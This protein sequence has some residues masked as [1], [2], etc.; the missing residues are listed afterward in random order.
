MRYRC[1]LVVLL[2]AVAGCSDES[3]ELSRRG[4]APQAVARAPMPRGL[5][6][7]F[8][9][10][11]AFRQGRQVRI[12]LVNDADSTIT[13]T[14]ATVSSDRFDEVVWSGEETF[15][16]E[17]DLEMDLPMARCGTR[18]SADVEL[19]YSVDGGP[20]TTSATVAEDRY[21]QVALLLDRDC[22]EYTL[23]DAATLTTG[24]PRIVGK[25]L[26]AEYRLPVRLT[27]TGRRDDV[28]FAGFDD[29]VLFS[30]IGEAATGTYR[31][32][33]LTTAAGP[34][35]VVLRVAPARCDPHALAED[36]IGTLFGVEVRAPGLPGNAS[37]YLPLSDPARALLRRSFSV[38]CGL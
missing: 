6:A 24:R 28:S 12:R 34:V 14:R 10:G 16:N 36:K 2:L 4:P 11:R 26:A 1:W 17:V 18:T 13:V 31:P 35:D 7:W 19:T 33:P 38:H 15:M 27:P 37:F 22:A 20:L 29:T 3:G 32:A 8:D 9:Q 30:S 5:T 25:G 21:G 23:D